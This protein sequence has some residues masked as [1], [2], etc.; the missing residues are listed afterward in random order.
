MSDLPT[1]LTE[2]QKDYA[3]FL[4]ALSSFYSTFVGKQRYEEYTAVKRLPSNMNGL[5]ESGNWLEPAAGLWHYKWSLYSAG[6]ANLDIGHIPKEDMTRNRDK[7]NSWL[8]GDSGG[9]QIGKGKWEGDW[10]AG[11]GCPKAQ[12]KR[13][14]VLAWMD[15]YMDY[16]M[17]LDIPAWVSRSPEGAAASQISS[18]QE[19]VDATKFN[20]EYFIKHR[21]GNCKFLNVLQGENFGQADDWYEQMKHFS[22]PKVYPDKHFNGWSMGGQNM[23]DIHLALKR[24]VTLRFDGLLEQGKQDFMHFLGTSKLEWGVMLTA[25]QRAVRKYHNPNFTITYD[26]ASPFLC[27]ANGQ[28]YTNWR[29]DHKGKWSYIMEPAPDDKG[30]SQD[31]RPWD[32]ECEKHHTNWYPSPLSEGM[33]VKDVCIYAPGDTNKNNKEGK[34][35]WDSF[36]YFLMMNHNVY[37]HI[38]SV[39]EGNKAMDSGS[40]PAWLVNETITRESVAEAIDQVFAIND[41]DEALDFIDHNQKLWM[42]VPGTRGAI[43]K[44]TV[45]ASAQFGALFE[46]V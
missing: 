15:A 38:R 44:K 18:Y 7:Q 2:S 32:E 42:R 31:T 6:H 17:I 29:L 13:E 23:C 9:F 5:V 26:C 21:N 25:V 19:A 45:N 37:T 39:Q 22:D 10:R 3:I 4:P 43:G 46:E 14:Q 20:N 8:L 35:S 40:Y 16:G 36:S 28:Q 34:T 11:S 30:Y 33:K 41:R 27:T 24:L 1:N 12:K